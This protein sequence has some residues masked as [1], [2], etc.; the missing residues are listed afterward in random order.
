M[1]FQFIGSVL[2]HPSARVSTQIPVQQVLG[3]LDSDESE[4]S[5]SGEVNKEITLT[6]KYS[7]DP[8]PWNP[9][10]KDGEEMDP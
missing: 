1:K 10:S 2:P 7:T 5:A 3:T 8:K 6:S 9:V 4:S